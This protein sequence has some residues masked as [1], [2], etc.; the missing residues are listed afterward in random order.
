[1]SKD[2]ARNPGHARRRSLRAIDPISQHSSEEADNDVEYQEGDGKEEFV[3]AQ[4][5]QVDDG[6][7]IAR[8]KNQRSAKNTINFGR[9]A[10]A[11]IAPIAKYLKPKKI[12]K[13]SEDG[14][15]KWQRRVESALIKMNAEMAALREQMDMQH[16]A[17]ENSSVLGPF[18]VTR[19]RSGLLSWILDFL[20]TSTK[21]ALKH[22]LIDAAIV[23]TVTLWMHYN[24]I[25]TE[26]LE[27]LI[28]TWIQQLR[29]ITFI[30]SFEKTAARQVP[31][32][33]HRSLSVAAQ[34]AR[35]GG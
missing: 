34:Q 14:N 11:I 12:E 30:R 10:G 15:I 32:A 17:V 18:K 19:R 20:I 3:D 21:T 5:S 13:S 6:E 24:G 31:L 35:L 23:A 8:D 22:V 27:R 28:I 16:E 1:M 26:R 29:R 2:G 7:K 9:E 4:D 25:P 33:V